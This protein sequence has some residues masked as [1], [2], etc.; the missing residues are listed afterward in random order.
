MAYEIKKFTKDFLIKFKG[1][2]F[3][4]YAIYRISTVYTHTHTHTHTHTQT[5]YT[6]IYIYTLTIRGGLREN[7]FN[8]IAITDWAQFYSKLL[9][10]NFIAHQ[11]DTFPT[12]VLILKKWNRIPLVTILNDILPSL[13]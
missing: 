6:Y 3:D 11:I 9:P 10:P 8:H 7:G 2:F 4:S 13:T 5:H 12:K 1:L